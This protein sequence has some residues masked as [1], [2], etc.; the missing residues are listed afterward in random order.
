MFLAVN[1][2]LVIFET[3]E[4]T[5]FAARYC[6]LL[7]YGGARNRNRKPSVYRAFCASCVKNGDLQ[8]KNRSM[9]PGPPQL[10]AR[11]VSG[12]LL[13]QIPPA[14]RSPSPHPLLEVLR[15]I[16]FFVPL[17]L[18]PSIKFFSADPFFL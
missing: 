3:L 14:I 12:I 1:H 15:Q 17:T 10:E 5:G 9:Y 16:F 13:R 18:D 4:N 6:I 8:Y 2:V 7:K 11:R